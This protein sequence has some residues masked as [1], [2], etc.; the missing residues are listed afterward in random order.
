MSWQSSLRRCRTRSLEWSSHR[1][2]S[3]WF[4]LRHLSRE[5]ENVFNCFGGTS[6]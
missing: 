6:A 1:R 2:S 3:T 4:V 5:T